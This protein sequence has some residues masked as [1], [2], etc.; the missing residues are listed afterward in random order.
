MSQQLI[1]LNLD[2]KRLRDDGY[3]IEIK[4]GHLFAHHIPYLNSSLKIKYGTIV[5]VLSLINPNIIGTPPDHTVYFSGEVPYN[6][7][8][9]PLNAIIL[10]SN[11]LQLSPTILV[12][13]HF[14]SRPTTGNY[15]S[16]FEKIRTYI[17]IL[18]SQAKFIE[19]K[20]SAKTFK[21]IPDTDEES[22][23]HYIDT[24][25]SRANIEMINTKFENQKIAIIGLGG[26][27]SYILDLVAKTPVAE[28]RLYDN[29]V[30]QQHN[31]YR[32]PGV[33]SIKKLNSQPK[34]VKYF[35]S[36]YSKLHKYIKPYAVRITEKNLH[37]LKGLSFVFI[38]IDKNEARALIISKLIK[39]GI[40]FIDV[41]L[42]VNF[43]E[44]NLMGTIRVTVG[45]S[46]KKDHINNRI[47][48]EDIGENDYSTN[49]QIADLNALN[50]AFAVVKWKKL[51]GFYQ[52]LKEEHNILYSINTGQVINDDYKT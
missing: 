29:D 19:S 40:P 27:G 8:G 23:F 46:S 20:V 22:V 7:D 50:A 33:P 47:G 11:D 44:N 17:E 16:Y 3:E 36:I 37:L 24:N 48:K 31:A 43:A 13:H 52:D 2:L 38:C 25:S 34:K 12:N 39:L 18:S 10:S 21:V 28:I 5:T 35:S 51:T 42:G 26:T 9:Q 6:K 41:G 45:T 14:S 15:P 1:N 30:F 32:S 4:G 49:I